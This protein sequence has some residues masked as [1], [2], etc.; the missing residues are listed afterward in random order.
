MTRRTLLPLL[1]LTPFLSAQE[2]AASARFILNG[3]TLERYIVRA[4]ADEETLKVQI[5]EQFYN[6]GRA[7]AEAD[8][9]FALP[10]EAAVDDLQL[11]MNGRFYRGDLLDRE[12]ARRI[13][14]DIVRRTRD[15]A[16]LEMQGQNLFRCRVFPIPPKGRVSTRLGYRQAVLPEES[17]RRVVIPLHAGKFQRRPVKE[18][19]LEIKLETQRPLQAVVCPTHDV[20]ITR[21]SRTRATISLKAR[22]AVLTKDLVLLYS[23]EEAPFGAVLA[24]YKRGRERGYFTLSIDTV[25][26]AEEA[27][28]S[29]R[30]V[31]VAVDTSNSM[32]RGGVDAAAAA[33]GDALQGLNEGDRYA[34]MSFSTE[35]RRLTSFQEVGEDTADQ[36][37]ALFRKHPVAGRTRLDA[38]IREATRVASKGRPATGIVLL[39][40]GMQSEGG[41]DPVVE[42]RQTSLLGNWL[43]VCG[44]GPMVDTL[45]LDHIGSRGGGDSVYPLEGRSLTQGVRHLLAT[46]RSV[47]LTDVHIEMEGAQELYPRR[48]AMVQ[49]GEPILVAGR[50]T[51]GGRTTV[52]IRAKINGEPVVREFKMRLNTRG[53]NPAVARI[54]AARRIGY[55]LDATRS[56]G[57]SN[58]HAAEIKRLGRS[59]GIVTPY[60]ALLVL[61]AADRKHYLRGLRRPQF[62]STGGGGTF[63]PRGYVTGPSSLSARLSDRIKTLSRATSAAQNPFE[64]LL[65]KNRSRMRRAG[66]RTFYMQK[67]GTWVQSDLVQREPDTPKRVTFLSD[68]WMTLAERGGEIAA[69]LALGRSVLFTLPSGTPVR[70]VP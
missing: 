39:T 55:L 43:G 26:A 2:P 25:F 70:V 61:E 40:D 37:R 4:E 49:V 16:L 68:T 31:V 7:I 47:P 27:A 15:P 5:E 17:M 21:Q 50:Y 67:D 48:A 63:A 44:V 18:F 62:N 65:G 20:R 23:A 54:W 59:F 64:D 24:S 45:L 33:I 8:Y 22:N 58:L 36:V 14:R 34:L 46:T 38:A 9:Y 35:A 51:K 56:H 12:R 29:P 53:G 13:Y 57:K 10:P 41:G 3:A 52:R 42:A 30:D 28:R 6:P 69:A 1:L 11:T 32:G 60:S 19:E 66:G